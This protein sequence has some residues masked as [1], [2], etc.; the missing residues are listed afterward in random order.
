MRPLLHV[1]VWLLIVF[2][3]AVAGLLRLFDHLVTH[4]LDDEAPRFEPPE[5]FPLAKS[6]RRKAS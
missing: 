2:L 5:Q 6:P 4:Y 3:L 1:W